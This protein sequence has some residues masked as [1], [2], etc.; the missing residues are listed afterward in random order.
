MRRIFRHRR[1][2]RSAGAKTGFGNEG[3]ERGGIGLAG[4]V[5]NLRFLA[6]E[7]DA[8]GGDKRLF[9]QD[10]FETA[11]AGLAGHAVNVVADFLLHGFLTG[12]VSCIGA[13][14]ARCHGGIW[15]MVGVFEGKSAFALMFR[16]AGQR[17]FLRR[18]RPQNWRYGSRYPLVALAPDAANRKKPAN[19]GSGGWVMA[20]PSAGSSAGGCPPRRRGGWRGIVVARI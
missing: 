13:D 14:R 12:R 7:I 17:W 11:G 8:G 5:S 4:I 2:D 1:R 6:G 9:V 16:H 15:G 18:Q 10:F 3:G 20:P 19:T